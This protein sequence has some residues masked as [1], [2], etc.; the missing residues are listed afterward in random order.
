M[1]TDGFPNSGIKEI[2]RIAL[3]RAAGIYA[4]VVDGT[5]R[6]DMFDVECIGSAEFRGWIWREI[7]ETTTRIWQELH[8]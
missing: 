5:R 8:R 6:D 2:H 3:E 1:V 4:V 7:C